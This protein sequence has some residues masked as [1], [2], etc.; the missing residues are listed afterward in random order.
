MDTKNESH[1]DMPLASPSTSLGHTA[2]IAGAEI[3]PAGLYNLEE[4]KVWKGWSKVHGEVLALVKT[5]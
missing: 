5:Y 3:Q 2:G 4:R 1:I